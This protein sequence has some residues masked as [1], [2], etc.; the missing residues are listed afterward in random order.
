MDPDLYYHVRAYLRKEGIT[1]FTKFGLQRDHT[2]KVTFA[3][4]EYD[5]IDKPDLTMLP[6][7][8]PKDVQREEWIEETG[9]D[10]YA[11]RSKAAPNWQN[12]SLI[13]ARQLNVSA[14]E[15]AECITIGSGFY[16]LS[17]FGDCTKATT[18]AIYA[19]E[20]DGTEKST[21]IL[22]RSLSGGQ[23]DLGRCIYFSDM[24][25]I[26]VKTRQQNDLT[27]FDITLLIE[28]L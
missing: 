20:S 22:T 26:R 28:K 1:D 8:L 18:T 15:A 2:G 10:I 5:L 16:R 23:F 25:S 12:V 9:Y 3:Q 17:L 13:P 6:R 4:W 14:A 21:A 24:T 27:S 7:A 19:V 11:G